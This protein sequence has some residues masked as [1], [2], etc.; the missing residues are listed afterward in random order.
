MIFAS[1]GGLRSCAVRGSDFPGGKT[2]VTNDEMRGLL[3]ENLLSP[4]HTPELN[5]P[6]TDGPSQTWLEVARKHHKQKF[7]NDAAALRKS[8]NQGEENKWETIETEVVYDNGSKETILAAD[9]GVNNFSVD[10]D[11]CKEKC[12]ECLEET[13][14]KLFCCNFGQSFRSAEVYKNMG[15]FFNKVDH[16][17]SRV[18]PLTFMV[19]NVA[20]WTLYMYIL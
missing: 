19:I 16:I 11:T 20:Y 12:W 5:S 17:A 2:I 9:N 8:A 7:K 14:L 18:F 15:D 1:L 6:T 4:I 3:D 10:N 13:I